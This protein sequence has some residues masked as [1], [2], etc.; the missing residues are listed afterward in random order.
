[1]GSKPLEVQLSYFFYSHFV[2]FENVRR[3]VRIQE[4]E[5]LHLL[6]GTRVAYIARVRL[7]GMYRRLPLKTD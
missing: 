5:E 6:R 4:S 7:H 3:L 2:V 1:M